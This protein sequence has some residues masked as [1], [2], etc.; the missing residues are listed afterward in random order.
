MRVL[1][2]HQGSVTAFDTDRGL[3]EVT[4]N[5]GRVLTFHCTSVADGSR[6]IAVGTPVCYVVVPGHRGRMEAAAVTASLSP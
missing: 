6:L 3:G 1:A 5:D 4:G 2:V